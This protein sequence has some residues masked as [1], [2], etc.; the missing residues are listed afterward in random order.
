MAINQLLTNYIPTNQQNFDNSQTLAPRVKEWYHS[1]SD[2][3]PF[4]SICSKC[5]VCLSTIWWLLISSSILFMWFTKLACWFI[6]L[7]LFL[8]S[9]L[10]VRAANFDPS[11]AFMASEQWGFLAC[12]NYCDTWYLFIMVISKDWWH[13]HL[14]SVELWLPVLMT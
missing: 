1:T 6:Y 2:G 12:P 9:P 14:F 3:D 5:V 7:L 4:H 11:L 10:L 13:S 8:T